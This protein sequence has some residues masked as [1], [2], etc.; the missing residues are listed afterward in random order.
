MG[1]TLL[2]SGWAFPGAPSL[3]FAFPYG[4]PFGLSILGLSLFGFLLF[5]FL[6]FGSLRVGFLR[7]CSPFRFSVCF[8]PVA[9]RSGWPS[10]FLLAFWLRVRFG[11]LSGFL[12]GSIWA[13]IGIPVG[14]Q[15]VSCWIS[16]WFS[17]WEVLIG[18][19]LGAR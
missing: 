4:I 10:A 15:M 9:S 5:G 17:Y 13:R 1:S 19:P 12:L 8:L 3:F 14:F 18:C 6:R 7:V 11:S 16:S 2:A